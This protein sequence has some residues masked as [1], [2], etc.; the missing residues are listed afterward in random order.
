MIQEQRWNIKHC[1]KF[2]RG[3]WDM[4]AY[5]HLHGYA[6]KKKIKC[7][8]L[9]LGTRTQTKNSGMAQNQLEH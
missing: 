2:V 8:A 4:G 9:F 6:K 5:M 7:V 3:C 1:S